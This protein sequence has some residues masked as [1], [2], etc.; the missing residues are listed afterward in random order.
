[1]NTKHRTTTILNRNLNDD[2]PDL[3]EELARD[4]DVMREEDRLLSAELVVTSPHYN[5]V[6]TNTL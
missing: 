1:M 6:L 5:A 4:G 3:R 2:S